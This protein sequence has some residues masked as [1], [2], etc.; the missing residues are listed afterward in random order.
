MRMVAI[1]LLLAWLGTGVLA[2]AICRLITLHPSRFT[3]AV[4]FSLFGASVVF[5]VLTLTALPL[6]G[7]E[8]LYRYL[9]HRVLASGELRTGVRPV[10][11]PAVTI[12]GGAG[13]AD[14]ASG[15][16]VAVGAL[17]TD[18]PG[19]LSTD[20]PGA[21]LTDHPKDSVAAFPDHSS[22]AGQ[23][24]SERSAGQHRSVAATSSPPGTEYGRQ[25]GRDLVPA[26]L[27]ND[28]VKRWG[29]QPPHRPRSRSRVDTVDQVVR[30][31]R[32]EHVEKADRADRTDALAKIDVSAASV[33]D[34]IERRDKRPEKSQRADNLDQADKGGQTEKAERPDKAEKPE[35][36][37]KGERPDKP[38]TIQNADKAEKVEKVEKIE[39]ADK[40]DKIEKA[41]K[42]E[43]AEKES[44]FAA[45]MKKFRISLPILLMI[46]AV[47]VV[48]AVVA[49]WYLS[50]SN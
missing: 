42:A 44:F 3:R 47:V 15:V 43:K 33:S 50:G 28:A 1:L 35:K 37:D 29:L 34:I 9:A 45:L 36:A 49:V 25:G 41:D 22:G 21:L 7:I 24:S 31:E 39:K 17:S 23:S 8:L 6:G 12:A 30:N 48:W 19:A 46:V 5:A 40:Q 16:A 11:R 2:F 20:H 27:R 38:D 4:I 26:T 10:G 14:A 32:P 18:H 13:E